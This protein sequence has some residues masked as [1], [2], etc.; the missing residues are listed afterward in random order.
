M[1]EIRALPLELQEDAMRLAPELWG[2]ARQVVTTGS[3][4]QSPCLSSVVR[5]PSRVG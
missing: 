2:T 4:D 3:A 1:T 5:L